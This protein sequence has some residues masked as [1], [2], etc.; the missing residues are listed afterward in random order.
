[1]LKVSNLN[2]KYKDKTI[3]KNAEFGVLENKLNIIIGPNGAGKSTLL[4]ILCGN[5]KAD[6]EIKNDYKDIF[7]L[8]Q[9][10]Y[11]PK[12][13]STFDYV[14]SIFF[15]N[16]FKW[17]LNEDEKR[18]TDEALSEME[19]SDKR[20]LDVENLSAGEIQKANIALGLLSGADLFLLD[21]PLSNMDLINE[22]KI[23]KKLKS[24]TDKG[25]TCVIVM[26]DLN[27]SLKF[28][29]YFLGID[30]GGGVFGCNG[31]EFFT[32]RNLKKL[33]NID[34]EII[35][36]GEKKYVQIIE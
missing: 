5:I 15:K 20:N 29:D 14:S 22:V 13:I 11:Y 27:L 18:F 35:N 31:E 21:E 34:F 28:G 4:K 32:S 1:M 19:L 7:Y 2:F 9:N 12:G 16:N 17:F 23:L 8:P 26:H 36:A 6:G 24:L 33:Y 25:I 10:L 3:F 30:T